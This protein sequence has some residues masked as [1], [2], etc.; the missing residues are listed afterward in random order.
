MQSKPRERLIE[1]SLRLFSTHGFH[2]TGID[3]ILAEAGVAK[4]TL[5][6]HFR[7]KDELILAALDRYETIFRAWLEGVLRHSDR[8]PDQ[9]ILDLFDKLSAWFG[10]STLRELTFQGSMLTNAAAEFGQPGHPV[11]DAVAAHVRGLSSIL[12]DTVSEA[13]LPAN[14]SNRLVVT[15]FGAVLLAQVYR[16][17][18]VFQDARLTVSAI[19]RETAPVP[20]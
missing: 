5:Y 16:D 20:A 10:A 17:P 14:L 19:L 3:R 2:A 15:M 7:S 4:M 13:G 6:R 11:H 1:T 12:E 9:R 8:P 18:R